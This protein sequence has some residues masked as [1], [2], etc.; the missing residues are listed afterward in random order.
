VAVAGDEH[1]YENKL[2]YMDDPWLGGI[3]II[4]LPTENHGQE[5]EVRASTLDGDSAT[6]VDSKIATASGGL[7]YH[8]SAVFVMPSAAGQGL[9]KRLVSAALAYIRED[10]KARSVASSPAEM[11]V[12]SW[13]KTAIRL[14]SSNG[15]EPVK[16]GKY[17]VGGIDRHAITMR[18]NC[19]AAE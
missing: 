9:G 12:D 2:S 16:E 18:L 8:V 15:F 10:I 13:N 4:K 14:Y 7:T 5:A 19:C 11:I 1:G 3:V 6:T 17:M